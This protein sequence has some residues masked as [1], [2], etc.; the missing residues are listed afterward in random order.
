MKRTFNRSTMPSTKKMAVITIWMFEMSFKKG[1]LNAISRNISAEVTVIKLNRSSSINH[2]SIRKFSSGWTLRSV[3]N[4]D[5]SRL[6]SGE[7]MW[8]VEVGG[9]GWVRLKE[10]GSSRSNQWS[11]QILFWNRSWCCQS[12]LTIGTGLPSGLEFGIDSA[13][14]FLEREPLQVIAAFHIS[15]Q[16]QEKYLEN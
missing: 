6:Y 16:N 15:K 9:C 11:D 7:G 2:C 12:G 5:S 13:R 4:C 14:V 3:A 10:T 1:L 8:G